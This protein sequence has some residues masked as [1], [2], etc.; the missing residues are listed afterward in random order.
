MLKMSVRQRPWTAFDPANKDHRQYFN[1]F[2]KTRSWR[3][4][5]VQWII[6]DD[7]QDVVHYIHKVL[8]N[9]YTSS[10]FSTKKPKTLAK[11]PKV[12]AKPPLRKLG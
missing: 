8:I 9:Y 7:S 6:G 1:E 11:K 3:N 2:L 4:C 12:I 5:P 10:E